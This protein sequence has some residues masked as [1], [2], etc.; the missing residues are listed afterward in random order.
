MSG[1]GS[2]G[3]WDSWSEFILPTPSDVLRILELYKSD[4]SSDIS[5]IGLDVLHQSKMTGSASLM[6]YWK[7]WAHVF[8]NEAMSIRLTELT[9]L[10]HKKNVEACHRVFGALDRT[11]L[12]CGTRLDLV[13]HFGNLAIE[14]KNNPVMEEIWMNYAIECIPRSETTAMFVRNRWSSLGDV[15]YPSTL[16]AFSSY[17]EIERSLICVFRGAT[18]WHYIAGDLYLTSSVPR[19]GSLHQWGLQKGVFIGHVA[20]S[21]DPSGN[22]VVEVDFSM[23]NSF[24][25][26]L[27]TKEAGYQYGFA[28]D[29]RQPVETYDYYMFKLDK[30]LLADVKSIKP[31]MSANVTRRLHPIIPD[32]EYLMFILDEKG[33]GDPLEAFTLTVS[34]E[35]K[36]MVSLTS[37]EDGA[38]MPV[39]LTLLYEPSLSSCLFELVLGDVLQAVEGLEVKVGESLGSAFSRRVRSSGFVTPA[40]KDFKLKLAELLDKIRE[41]KWQL[42]PITPIAGACCQ[43]VSRCIRNREYIASLYGPAYTPMYVE[44]LLRQ[45]MYLLV[46]MRDRDFGRTLVLNLQDWTSVQRFSFLVHYIIFVLFVSCSKS[47]LPNKG[48]LMAIADKLGVKIVIPWLWGELFELLAKCSDTREFVVVL[49][50]Y[51]LS[52]QL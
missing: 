10:S 8:K 46:G 3:V 36:G 38:V 52:G 23:T 21:F 26:F 35:I 42:M 24:I 19:A 50:I 18:L 16:Y 1:S 51:I 28:V 29:S 43:W 6:G 48:A 31:V 30:A 12:P 4:V 45:L 49:I 40:G 47:M 9:S 33:G 5:A 15:R 41:T 32:G 11:D 14:A 34:D 27:K 22:G 37:L 17:T 7:T 20:Q 2:L 25:Q 39:D 13:C 44:T